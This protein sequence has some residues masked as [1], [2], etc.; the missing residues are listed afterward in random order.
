MEKRK[1][2]LV[3]I[4]VGMFLTITIVTAIFL[5]P[6]RNA[7]A[8]ELAAYPHGLSA[9][10]PIFDNSGNLP[11]EPVDLVR[12]PG[13]VPGL[14]QAPEGAITTGSNLHVGPDQSRPGETVISVRQPNTV[15]AP[16]PAASTTRPTPTQSAPRPA[17]P[18]A[19]PAAPAAS[20]PPANRP[21]SPPQ[22]AQTSVH[23]DYWVQAGAFSTVASAEG[24][25]Q[26]LSSRGITSIIENREVNGRTVFRVRL[27]PYTSQNE[28][29]YWLSLIRGIS[30]FEDSQI[31]VTQTR[32]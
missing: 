5:L 15:T 16:A 13:D 23:N 26:N 11:F 17:A 7:A 32:R 9:Q 31:R 30:G 4:S 28:A 21:T 3:A 19:T 1:L 29:D 22:P 10:P 20:T 24:V 12:R 8:A 6:P 18:A 2:L 25:R 14:Q 27:G